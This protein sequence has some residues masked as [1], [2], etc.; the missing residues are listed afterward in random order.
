MD[1]T[2]KAHL[3]I[4]FAGLAITRFVEIKTNLSIKKVI[5]IISKVLTHKVKNIKTGETV[6]IETQTENQQ[7]LKDLEIIKSVGH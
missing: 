4:V 1:E 7:L 3:I 6:L 2:I 5:K